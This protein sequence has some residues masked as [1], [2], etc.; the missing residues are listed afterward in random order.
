MKDLEKKLKISENTC[1]Y[2]QTLELAK[3]VLRIFHQLGLRWNS[4]MSYLFIHNWDNF[5]EN[6]VYYPFKGECSALVYAHAIGY[7]VISA[8]EF[9]ALHTEGKEFD[10]ENYEPK[11]DLK[12]FPKE[13]IARMIECQVEQGNKIDVSVFERDNY[14]SLIKGGFHWPDTKEG[15][16]FWRDVLQFKNFALYFEKYPKRRK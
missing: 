4:E 15:F 3:Q 7:K 12:G 16:V 1:I 13:I 6:T 10:L 11:G 2:C 8:E 14:N 5:K 9:I